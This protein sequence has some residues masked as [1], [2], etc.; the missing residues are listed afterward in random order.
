MVEH[1]FIRGGRKVA[2]IEDVSVLKSEQGKGVGKQ[3]IE[4]CVDVAKR[5]QCYKIILDCSNDN[6]PFYEKCGFKKHENCMRLDLTDNT[7]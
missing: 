1:K 3:L 7:V 5:Y 4:H 6:V 2:H